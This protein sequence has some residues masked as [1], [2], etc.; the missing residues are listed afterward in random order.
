MA[1]GTGMELLCLIFSTLGL[2][3]ATRVRVCRLPTVMCIT[4]EHV[5]TG[6]ETVA[7]D[8][9]NNVF[10]YTVSYRQ[11]FVCDGVYAAITTFNITECVSVT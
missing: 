11:R 5:C 7:R 9:C 8:V 1:I 4:G 6:D 10:M 3:G 2:I